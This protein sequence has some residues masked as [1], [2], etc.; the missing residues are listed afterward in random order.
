MDWIADG[1]VLHAGTLNGN[2]LSLAAA[3]AT[4]DALAHNGGELYHHLWRRGE[5]LKT[6]IEQILRD[7][8]LTAVTSGVGPVF[9]VSFMPTPAGNY[10]ELLTADTVLYG[11][12]ALAL[13]DEGILVLPDGRW[14]ISAAHTDEDIEVTLRAVER[15]AR[16]EASYSPA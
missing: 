16:G 5:R 13:L 9:Q 15:A 12:F 2:P 14:Y 1:K 8:G 6:G 7:A 4:L 10:R 11:E 3:A